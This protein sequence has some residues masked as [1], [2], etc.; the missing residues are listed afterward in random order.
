M[1]DLNLHELDLNLLKTFV[2]LTEQGSVTAAAEKLSLAQ[3]TVS[4]SLARLRE[5]FD[6]PLFVRST[7]GLEPTPL[8]DTLREPVMQALNL[9]Q[10]ALSRHQ[11][12]TAA[13]STRTFNLLMTDA[14]ELL[15]VPP[16][17]KKI[18][19]LA[20][21]VRIVIHQASRQDYKNALESGD[22]DLAI[23][24]L[25]LGQVDLVQQ[26]LLVEAFEGYARTGHP[27]LAS[28]TLDE[29]LAAE[30]LVV[31]RPAVADL[32]V[33]R[34]LGQLDAKRR[35]ALRLA[36]YLPAA[37]V[38]EQ[39]DLIAVLPATLADFH[40]H[41]KNLGRFKPPFDIEPITLRQ[42]WHARSTHDEGCR[43]LRGRI[44]ALF[45]NRAA[46]ADQALR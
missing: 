27:I 25:P 26:V 42:F 20:P 37:P 23:G 46:S 39:T 32:H 31:G 16:L 29:F 44:A 11:T 36:H 38:L 41:F 12:F 30:H 14:G 34:A 15:F 28:P 40:A 9:L 21:R 10:D 6:D 3:S 1:R 24:Q 45:Q 35:I 4:H 43:W 17:M 2:V 7:R 8:A 18:R 33:Q 5:A 19:A 22:I 13:T